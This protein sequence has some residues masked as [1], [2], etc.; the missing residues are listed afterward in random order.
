MIFPDWLKVYGDQAF[1]GRCATESEEQIAFFDHIRLNHKQE[2]VLALHQRNEGKRSYA[3]AKWQK[4]EGLTKGA[5][6][7][8][9]PGLPSFVCELKRRDHT[10]SKWKDGQIEYLEAALKAG[11]F[12]CVA[13]G[14]QAAYEAFK[15]WRATSDSWQKWEMP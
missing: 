1:R 8:I 4:R 5:S 12:A 2:A 13:L 15:I 7:I 6:D 14:Y 3:Q 9:I 10:K 11:C